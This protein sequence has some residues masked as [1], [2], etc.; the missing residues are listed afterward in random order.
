MNAIDL[1]VAIV[2]AAVG[3]IETLGF[4]A[5]LAAA[6]AMVKAGEVTLVYYGIAEKGEFLVAVR[7]K[8]AEV[9]TSVAAGIAATKEVYGAQV[10]AHYIIPNPT[11]N[12]EAV[13]PIQYTRK[14][15]QFR[16]F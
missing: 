2:P 5:V 15:E 12:I 14:V 10:I 6:D 16:T 9:K 7:G 1:G 8:V 4:P 11:E 13:L 3:V